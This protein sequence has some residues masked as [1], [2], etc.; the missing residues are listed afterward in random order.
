MKA[1]RKVGPGPKT[2]FAE[3]RARLKSG[4]Y[5]SSTRK[6]NRDYLNDYSKG[7]QH[8]TSG[9]IATRVAEA[10]GLMA[11]IDEYKPTIISA[12]ARAAAS[13]NSYNNGPVLYEQIN[14][15]GDGNCFY[16]SLYRAAKEHEDPGMLDRVFTILGADK[17]Q[18]ATEE[19]GQAAL[20]SAIS[21][22]YR[23]KFN[24]RSGPFEMLK[25]NYGTIQFT[26]WIREAT[27]KQA[28]IYR[29]VMKYNA[30]KDGKVEFYKDLAAVI[31]TNKEYASDIDYM[32]VSDILNAGGVRM[33][34]SNISPKGPMF[35]G[36]P[37]LYIKRL[38]YDH[39]NYWRRIKPAPE[40]PKP[41]SGP[42]KPAL[43]PPKP[44]LELPKPA[45]LV[46]APTGAAM[47]PRLAP[48][49]K[50]SVK[51][52]SDSSS[53]NSTE[54]T[55]IENENARQMLLHKLAS[56]MDL[57]TR[58]IEKCRRLKAGVDT[59]RAELIKLGKK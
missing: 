9:A 54:S 7:R 53:A 15:E 29:N 43:E 35:D 28:K 31:G 25:T 3:I 47:P 6:R 23:T 13:S 49:S 44:A 50:L 26:G 48:S 17:A 45:S 39:Y 42:P 4:A 27:S 41:A 11:N 46:Q 18:I 19:T 8:A 30:K 21:T 52:N 20:R 37:A 1:T 57:H 5:N 32:V 38:T 58:C 22:Y 51:V 55:N 36:K 24:D 2:R 10:I 12:A 59:T 34:S 56:Q 14:V 40:P 16:R 33:V